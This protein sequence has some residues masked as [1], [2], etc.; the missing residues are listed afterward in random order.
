MSQFPLALSRAPLERVS[1]RALNVAAGVVGVV[2]ILGFAA[3]I[4]WPSR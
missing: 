1:E 4:A 2:A 3:A